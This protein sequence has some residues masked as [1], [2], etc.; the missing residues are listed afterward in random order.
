M[1]PQR[2]RAGAYRC[3]S[4]PSGHGFASASFSPR[5]TTT[6]LPSTCGWCHQPPQGTHTPERLDMP[7]VHGERPAEAGLSHVY[8][9]ALVAGGSAPPPIR[10]VACSASLAVDGGP[11]D[12]VGLGDA[13]AVAL[14]AGEVDRRGVAVDRTLVL[15]VVVVAERLAR[16]LTGAAR[17]RRGGVRPDAA[18]RSASMP[19]AAGDGV[20]SICSASSGWAAIISCMTHGGPARSSG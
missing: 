12:Q 4:C 6:Q 9:L 16:S 3:G 11:R 7:G 20:V 15:A 19:A 1:T 8:A 18:V 2:A 17:S 14:T 5:L 10:H 13:Q